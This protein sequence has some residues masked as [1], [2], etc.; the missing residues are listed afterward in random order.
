[1]WICFNFHG[2][3]FCFWV[4]IYYQIP[5]VKIPDPDPGP[6]RGFM[7]DATV[8]AT[9]NEAARHLTD[10]A[11]RHAVQNGVTAGLKAMQHKAGSDISISLEAPKG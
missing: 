1:M 3:R 9:I 4:P 10:E 2:R 5:I 8:L 11:V 6:Y 7:V